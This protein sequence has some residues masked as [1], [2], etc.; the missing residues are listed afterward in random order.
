[1]QALVNQEQANQQQK[2]AQQTVGQST[3]LTQPGY[4]PNPTTIDPTMVNAPGSDQPWYANTA[5]SQTTNAAPAQFNLGQLGAGWQTPGGPQ[6]VGNVQGQTLSPDLMAALS[7]AAGVA[8]DYQG[9][10]PQQAQ[11]ERNLQQTLAQFGVTGGGAVAADQ[12]LQAQL[13]AAYAPTVANTIQ[14]AQNLQFQGGQFDASQLQSAALANQGTQ[15]TQADLAANI[16]AT[17]AEQYNSQLAN[18]LGINTANSQQANLAN[19]AASNNMGQFNANNLNNMTQFNVGQNTQN[20]QFNASQGLQAA[21]ANQNASN[22]ASQWNAN[23]YNTT[24]AAN[25]GIY[26]QQQQQ[27]LQELMQNYYAQMGAFNNINSTGQQ[28][29]NQQGLQYG[30]EVTQTQSPWQTLFQGA[31]AAAPFFGP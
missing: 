29:L 30:G 23:A 12:Q 19:A 24:N 5:F 27:L 7:P 13:A 1:M 20:N 28:G 31:Q 15:L 17:N 21:L 16:G 4:I 11:S 3:S 18:A 2:Q 10:A 22:N 8:L 25:T 14:Q 26:D 9:F 6:A